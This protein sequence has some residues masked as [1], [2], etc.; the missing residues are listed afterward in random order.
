MKPDV[1]VLTDPANNSLITCHQ[2]YIAGHYADELLGWMLA[3]DD[4]EREAPVIFGR[5][6]PTKRMSCAF[7]DIGLRYRYSGQVKVAKPWPAVLFYVLT[8]LRED[9]ETPFNYALCNLY[10]D[11]EAGIG[12]HADDEAAIVKGSHIVGLSLGA[13]RDF[14]IS[15][16]EGERVT[17]VELEHGS[18]VAMW[19]DTQAHYKHALP[20]RTKV[21]KPRVSITFRSMKVA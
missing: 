7:G 9:L 19:D 13:E 5:P 2:N 16:K 8:E 15:T 11:G 17:S 3:M 12:A 6:R 4:W 18:L 21:S 1:T 10:P 20:P 14:I